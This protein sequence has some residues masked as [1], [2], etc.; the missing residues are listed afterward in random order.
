MYV[1]VH[2]VEHAWL[3]GRSGSRASEHFSAPLSSLDGVDAEEK[4]IEEEEE[5]WPGPGQG[6][7]ARERQKM[8]TLILS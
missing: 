2:G 3:N 6:Q 4:K 5:G 8:A 1:L 7:L